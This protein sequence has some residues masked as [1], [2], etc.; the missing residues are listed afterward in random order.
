METFIKAKES[1]VRSIEIDVWLTTDE[2]FVIYHGGSNGEFYHN[3]DSEGPHALEKKFAF[4]STLEECL[5]AEQEIRL[6]TLSSLLDYAKDELFV[7]I[8]VKCPDNPEIKKLYNW[9]LAA[10]RL[11][12]LLKEYDFKEHCY[13]SSFHDDFLDE[14]ISISE[15]NEYHVRTVLIGPRSL[16]DKPITKEYLKSM[17]H[18]GYN[19]YY[20][21]VS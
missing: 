17:K 3:S 11:F 14:F 13:V 6:T 2:R 21:I 20:L 5:K 12:E 1:G 10:L 15:T 8:E 7:N 16:N 19:A 9:K 18:V 4:Q